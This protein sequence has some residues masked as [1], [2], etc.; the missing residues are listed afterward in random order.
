MIL[1]CVCVLFILIIILEFST[2]LT[3]GKFVTKE[4][5]DKLT[6]K[7]NEKC[8]SSKGAIHFRAY[9]FACN[10]LYCLTGKWW[11]HINGNQ[12]RIPRF[13]KLSKLLDKKYKELRLL[14]INKEDD[15][16]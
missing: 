11:F 10:D 15:F 2:Y 12:R 7:L 9:Q 3:Y 1:I 5:A 8:F 14:E 13:S 4:Q 16:F 6:E